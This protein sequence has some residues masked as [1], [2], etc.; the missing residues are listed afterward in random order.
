MRGNL[1]SF[2]VFIDPSG[3][4][5]TELSGLPD[6]E[7][8]NVFKDTYTRNYIRA[9]LREGHNR[10]DTLHDYLEKEVQAL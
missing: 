5:M 1:I 3:V 2:Q 10:L 6:E 9:L 7:I 8:D 4:I